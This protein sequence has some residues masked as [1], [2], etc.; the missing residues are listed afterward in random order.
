VM[1]AI[2]SI[3]RARDEAARR[4][5]LITRANGAHQKL[6]GSTPECISPTLLGTIKR[7]CSRCGNLGDFYTSSSSVCKECRKLE[8]RIYHK[9]HPERNKI[10]WERNQIRRYGNF[11]NRVVGGSCEICGSKGKLDIHHIDGNG[12]NLVDKGEFSNNN[13]AN[14]RTLCRSCHMK[15]HRREEKLVGLSK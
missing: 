3:D 7:R 11:R 10:R 12:R 5:D 4:R 8:F 13:R 9:N 14:L 1:V 2:D 15:V 6:E